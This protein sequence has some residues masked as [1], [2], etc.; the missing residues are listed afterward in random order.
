MSMEA[1]VPEIGEGWRSR[2]NDVPIIV[3]STSATEVSFVGAAFL[4]TYSL[5]DFKRSFYR[6][7]RGVQE[8]TRWK[9][10]GVVL[11]SNGKVSK[12]PRGPWVV[13]V[14]SEDP[15]I[16]YAN[17][18]VADLLRDGTLLRPQSYFKL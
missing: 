1:Q 18:V 5:A 12:I 10:K 8:F 6:K 9:Y 16:K 14:D 11:V 13:Q 3:V 17:V 15:E 2:C 4:R 7:D